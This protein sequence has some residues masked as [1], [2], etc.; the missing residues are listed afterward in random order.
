MRRKQKPPPEQEQVARNV[1]RLIERHGLRETRVAVPPETWE[2]PARLSELD[3]VRLY[4]TAAGGIML[5]CSNYG[6]PPPAAL[7]M[8]PHPPLYS[9]ACQSYVRLFTSPAAMR[10][11]IRDAARQPEK[12]GHPPF[13]AYAGNPA[14][15]PLSATC[16]KRS[17]KPGSIRA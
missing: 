13:G 16:G 1:Q 10:R 2:L 6:A 4:R 3:H 15:A 14:K 11:V 17:I 8:E 7:A 9:F 5:L 12:A